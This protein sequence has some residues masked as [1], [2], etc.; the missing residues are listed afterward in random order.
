M[1]HNNVKLVN[2]GIQLVLELRGIIKILINLEYHNWL[3]DCY[4]TTD[5]CE[6]KKEFFK[7]TLKLPYVL[8]LQTKPCFSFSEIKERC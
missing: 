3:F 7:Y 6:N 1:L 2:S 4:L 5:V 8:V